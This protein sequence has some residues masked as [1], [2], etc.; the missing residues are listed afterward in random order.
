MQHKS[1]CN[2]EQD[3]RWIKMQHGSRCN[4]DQDATRIKLQQE[5]RCKMDQDAT[6]IKMQCGSICN[7][8]HGTLCPF[9]IRN[10][11]RKMSLFWGHKRDLLIETALNMQENQ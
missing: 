10:F 9:F 4:M 7:M 1:R 5:S 11:M 2:K 8:N 3:E 6:W